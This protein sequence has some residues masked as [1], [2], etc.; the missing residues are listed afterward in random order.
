MPGRVLRKG[1]FAAVHVKSGCVF[2]WRNYRSLHFDA[3]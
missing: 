2:I 1:W 3:K